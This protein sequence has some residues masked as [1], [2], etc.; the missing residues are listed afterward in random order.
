MINTFD[1]I[2]PSLSI[3]TKILKIMI[4]NEYITKITE[5]KIY[6]NN[7]FLIILI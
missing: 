2:K 7:S 1:N 4:I 5:K 6:K 3:I